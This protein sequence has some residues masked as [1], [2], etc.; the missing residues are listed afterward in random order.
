VQSGRGKE[1]QPPQLMNRA[2]VSTQVSSPKIAMTSVR[3]P[4]SGSLTL[5]YN[6]VSG[7]AL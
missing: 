7:A 3:T 1:P 6:F 4:S 5:N 2:R